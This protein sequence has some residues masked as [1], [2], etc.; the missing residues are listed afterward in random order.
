MDFYRQLQ[1]DP[2]N[3]PS[4]LPTF[5][6]GEIAP[7]IYKEKPVDVARNDNFNQ[8]LNPFGC[9][10]GDERIECLKQFEDH[11]PRFATQ[12]RWN[13]KYY[14]SYT[15]QPFEE[16]VKEKIAED[17]KKTTRNS[18]NVEHH[19]TC[20]C[21]YRSNSHKGSKCCDYEKSRRKTKIK[22]VFEVFLCV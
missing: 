5:D 6:T 18:C 3:N 20:P 14:P 13:N 15:H 22:K 12:E 11:D 8:M 2:P 16:A 9:V 19:K 1:Y 4:G 17:F 10:Q 7:T 21:K